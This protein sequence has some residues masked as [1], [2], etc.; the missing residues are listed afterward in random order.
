MARR[1]VVATLKA[2]QSGGFGSNGSHAQIRYIG[3][4]IPGG[5]TSKIYVNGSNSASGSILIDKIAEISSTATKYT[6]IEC[7][8]TYGVDPPRQ[9]SGSRN[10]NSRDESMLIISNFS[11]FIDW[12]HPGGG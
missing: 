2:G 7:T 12:D 5:A 6:T 11:L 4:S 1:A 3:S 9:A 8:A 10:S